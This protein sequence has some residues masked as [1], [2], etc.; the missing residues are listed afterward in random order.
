MTK[1]ED[2]VKEIWDKEPVRDA[3][4]IAGVTA[5]EQ[6]TENVLMRKVDP[7]YHQWTRAI[8]NAGSNTLSYFLG[9]SQEE[10]YGNK[11]NGQP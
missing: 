9:K 4:I 1:I 7:K 5:I 11:K 8:V 2:K 6:V 3:T 10:K